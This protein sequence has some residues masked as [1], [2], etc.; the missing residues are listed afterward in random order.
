MKI[1]IEGEVASGK[2]ILAQHLKCRIGLLLPSNCVRSVKVFEYPDWK[3]LKK[4]E[5]Q[6]FLKNY[7][8]VIC[9]KI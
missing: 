6:E 9:K 1:I 7:H 3:R 8:V 4:T 2:S 5:K